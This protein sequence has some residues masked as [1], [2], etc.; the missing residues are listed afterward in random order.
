[1]T[2]AERLAIGAA[3]SDEIRVIAEAGIRHRHPTWTDG[4]VGEALAWILLGP[5]LARKVDRARLAPAR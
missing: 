3:L 4:Q 1:M 2:P 5:E